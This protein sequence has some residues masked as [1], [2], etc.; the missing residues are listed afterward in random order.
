MLK[1]KGTVYYTPPKKLIATGYTASIYCHSQT[2]SY[3][4]YNSQH[5]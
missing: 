1:R 4:N 5:I 2:L 3:I